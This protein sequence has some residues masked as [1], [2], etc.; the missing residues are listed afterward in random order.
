VERY[1]E[2]RANDGAE[3]RLTLERLIAE[4]F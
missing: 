3:S 1:L 2:S 4:G